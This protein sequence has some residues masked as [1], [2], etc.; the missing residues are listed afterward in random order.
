MQHG[1]VKPRSDKMKIFMKNVAKRAMQL[2]IVL[3]CMTCLTSC[4]VV[5]G[6]AG[7]IISLPFR[8]INAIC[9]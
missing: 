6:L 8:L 7:F 5:T 1:V 4:S 2:G 9:P 3:A